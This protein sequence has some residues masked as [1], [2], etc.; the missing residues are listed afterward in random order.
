MS[1]QK[2]MSDI[3]FMALF[4]VYPELKKDDLTIAKNYSVDEDKALL[5]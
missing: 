1:K 2:I 5:F 4:K 3:I